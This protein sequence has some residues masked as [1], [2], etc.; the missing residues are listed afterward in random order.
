MSAVKDM[1]GP[2]FARLLVL[3]R[4]FTGKPQA[5]W[6]CECDCGGSVIVRGDHLRESRVRS[7]GC[8]Q[9]E[10]G[11]DIGSRKTHGMSF[12]RTYCSWRS[13]L[14]RCYDVNHNGYHNYGGRG[15]TVC[16]RWIDSFESFLSDMKERPIGK[17]NDRIDNDGN[18]EPGNCRWAT[19]KEQ[20]NNQRPRV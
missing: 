15:I 13:M 11:S 14:K 10:N 12:A 9:K 20:R 2:V 16:D 18:Y 5:E 17:T 1:T 19:P 3:E 6:M 4:A 8:L 7:C